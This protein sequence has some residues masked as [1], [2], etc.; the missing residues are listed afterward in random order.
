MWFHCGV[1][2]WLGPNLKPVVVQKNR[3]PE[4]SCILAKL[5]NM[6]LK[7]SCFSDCWKVASMVPV[8]KNVA[9]RSTAPNANVS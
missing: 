6:C 4:R 7:E 2:P 3:E 5:F 9:E 8:F 1:S